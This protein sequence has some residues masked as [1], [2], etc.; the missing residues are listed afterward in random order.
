MITLDNQ[1]KA[2]IIA[3]LVVLAAVPKPSME[4]I[5]GWFAKL[6]P[7]GTGKF[8][9]KS[10][11]IPAVS[12]FFLLSSETPGPTPGPNPTPAVV[13]DRLDK[14]ADDY[15]D[16]LSEVWK[17]YATEGPSMKDDDARL[18][19]LNNAQQA[20]YTAAYDAYITDA[21][22]TAAKPAD[23]TSLSQKLKDRKF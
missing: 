13:T 10:L 3:A 12:I 11:I 7:S 8:S 4:T 6:K 14:C 15:R 16:L 22:A 17:S 18:Q 1:T 20:A 23:A 5:K 19:W 21:K 9:F 2:V